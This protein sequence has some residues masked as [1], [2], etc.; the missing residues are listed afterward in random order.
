MHYF[1][2]VIIFLFSV[3]VCCLWQYS[4]TFTYNQNPLTVQGVLLYRFSLRLS[5][6]CRAVF[7][8]GCYRCITDTQKIAHR[9]KKRLSVCLGDIWRPRRPKP[10]KSQN[11]GKLG[12]FGLFFRHFSPGFLDHRSQPGEHSRF[13][14]AKL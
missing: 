11:L 4:N 13:I 9:G 14:V 8:S 12:V 2:S 6:D 7:L 1:N 5:G 3:R 10:R